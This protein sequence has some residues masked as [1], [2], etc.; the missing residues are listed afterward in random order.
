MSNIL[1]HNGRTFIIGSY[2]VSKALKSMG[3]SLS[4]IGEVIDTQFFELINGVIFY[5]AEYPNFKEGKP[6]DFSEADVYELLDSTGG[7]NG[8]FIQKFT[9]VMLESINPTQIAEQSTD[10]STKKKPSHLRRTA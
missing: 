7:Y 2:A 6:T 10:T 9:A 4:N 8:E 5:A 3:F 1:E